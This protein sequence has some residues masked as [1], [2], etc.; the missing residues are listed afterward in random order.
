MSTSNRAAAL[1]G[2]RLIAALSVAVFHFVDAWSVDG[3]HSHLHFFPTMARPAAYGFL[4]VDLFFIISGFVICMSGWGRSVADF[5]ASRVARLFPAYWFAILATTAGADVEPGGGSAVRAVLRRRDRDV[6]DVPGAGAVPLSG[7]VGLCWLIAV[8]QMD[9]GL[10]PL[11]YGFPLPWWPAALVITASFGAVL[12]VA[13]HWLDW[14]N[15]RWLTVAGAL[16]CQFYLLHQ[17]IGYTIIRFLFVRTGWPPWLL[18]AL[19]VAG[20]LLV[21]WLV[22]LCIERPIGPRLRAAVRDALIGRIARPIPHPTAGERPDRSAAA[23]RSDSP[24]TNEAGRP[25]R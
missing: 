5:A 21:S 7:I 13:L 1:D 4:G 17:R 24:A 11:R 15:W 2:L 12:A 19:V 8:Y 6:P 14:M 22:H 3:Y 16:T 9:A 23:R 25:V 10:R 18:V 20:V